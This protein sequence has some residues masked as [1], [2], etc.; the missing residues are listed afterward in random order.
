[1]FFHLFF[2]FSF[3]K[4]CRKGYFK[5]AQTS[6]QAVVPS[7][8]ATLACFATALLALLGLALA[9]LHLTRRLDIRNDSFILPGNHGF[10]IDLTF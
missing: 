10:Y 8:V 1:M 9:R 2:P 7:L 3:R 6:C 4:N 5:E